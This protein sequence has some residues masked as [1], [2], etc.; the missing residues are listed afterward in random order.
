MSTGKALR[1]RR[2][3][4]PKTQSTLMFAFSHGTSAPEVLPGLENPASRFEAA[5]A[6]GADCIFIAPGLV[7]SLAPMIGESRDVGIVAKITSTAS[8]GGVRHQERLIATVE[9]CAELGCDG[10][11]AMI[12]FA[13]ENEPDVISL[14]AQV[15]EACDRLG[16]PYIAEAEFPN[17]YTDSG[18]DYATKWGLPYLKRSARLCAELGADIVKSNWPGSGEEFA[19]I[20]DCV[21]IPVVVAGGSREGDLDLLQ[22]VADARA[23]GAVG[24]SVGRNIFQHDEPAAMVAAISAVVRGTSSPEEA[25]E[26]HVKERVGV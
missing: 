1:M 7:H 3:I 19:E 17:A 21:S 26:T 12:P 10:V 22:K 6:G 4:D 2:I 16:M 5:R 13:P 25:L 23:A 18:E 14:T 8:R 9:H 11:V 20:V 24:C 15:G